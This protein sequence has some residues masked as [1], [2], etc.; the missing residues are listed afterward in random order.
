MLAVGDERFQAKC[1]ETFEQMRAAGKTVLFV[2]HDLEALA[3]FCAR[4]VLIE[5]GKQIVLGPTA[6]V[7]DCYRSRNAHL[8]TSC[9]T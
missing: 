4:A 8:R 9:R 6:E 3:R 5:R 1:F 7:I 2:S